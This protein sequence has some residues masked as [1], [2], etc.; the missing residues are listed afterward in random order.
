MG[1]EKDLTT[2]FFASEEEKE[3]YSAE[4]IKEIERQMLEHV[5]EYEIDT[6]FVVDVADGD[7]ADLLTR[8]KIWEN[9]NR[10][11]LFRKL[12]EEIGEYAE[13]IEFENGSTN[14]KKKF[15]DVSA[16]DMLEEEIC[17]VVMMALALARYEGLN[18]RTVLKNV[19]KKL[20]KH[21]N[22]GERG[23][24]KTNKK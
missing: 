3:K 2:K 21:S 10:D 8:W 20:E 15:G 19:S 16:D 4:T 5:P 1:L 9:E 11:R 17:D 18:I 7:I 22:G 24:Q 13:A 12:I 14:K 23:A 6:G